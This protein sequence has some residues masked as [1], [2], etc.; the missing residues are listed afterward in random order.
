MKTYKLED[1][2]FAVEENNDTLGYVFKAGKSWTVT[3]WRGTVIASNLDTKASA[4]SFLA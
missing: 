3:D 1:G 2:R 4:I